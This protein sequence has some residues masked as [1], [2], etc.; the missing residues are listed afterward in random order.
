MIK[1]TPAQP[2][3][4]DSFVHVSSPSNSKNQQT[5]P[6]PV[7]T[8][9]IFSPE[10]L[11]WEVVAESSWPS[12]WQGSGAG[13]VG[14]SASSVR[15]AVLNHVLFKMANPSP[16]GPPISI[17]QGYAS[18]LQSPSHSRF[19]ALSLPLSAESDGDCFLLPFFVVEAVLFRYC[20]V[21]TPQELSLWQESL[22]RLKYSQAESESKP[23]ATI[24]YVIPLLFLSCVFFASVLFIIYV[25][26]LISNHDASSGDESEFAKAYI[27]FINYALSIFLGKRVGVDDN[28]DEGQCQTSW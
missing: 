28:G 18:E 11:D 13:T 9:K 16:L 22:A 21:S 1:P 17:L 20:V 14:A 6:V 27:R 19:V 12:Q 8:P 4:N 3:T 24:L 5:A 15:I 23:K 26:L 2:G 25:F 10:D 7:S